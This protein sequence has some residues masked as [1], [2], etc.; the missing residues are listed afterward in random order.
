MWLLL[1]LLGCEKEPVDLRD[2]PEELVVPPLDGVD[3]RAV[4]NEAL[5]TAVNIDMR[6]PWRGHVDSFDRMVP[7]CPDVYAGTPDLDIDGLDEDAPGLAWYDHCQD[8][9]LRFGGFEY[10]ETWLQ[11][12]DN[13]STG[14]TTVRAERSLF[15]DGL[16]GQGDEV[17]FEWDGSAA[18][19]LEVVSAADYSFWAYS[20]SVSGTVTGSAVFPADHV[21]AGGWRA[22]LYVAAKGGN[23]DEVTVRGNV[24]WFERRIV[25]RFDSVAVD[26]EFRGPTGATPDDCQ[27]EPRG[28]LGVRDSDANWY[29]LVF[30]PRYDEDVTDTDYPNDPYTACDGC[31]ML[32]VRGID[33]GVEVCPDFSAL[34]TGALAPPAPDE[35]ALPL[36]EQ[37]EDE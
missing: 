37:L 6:A 15:G 12:S 25:G 17:L 5:L 26:L 36:R 32:Y 3:L 10:W 33:Q 28:W 34:W 22:D 1:T 31:G 2:P 9:A 21:D 18:D 16:V 29:D 24:F 30:E 7:G 8:G 23:T 14:E 20:S 4:Y 35:F 19:A 27:L 11:A 13:L